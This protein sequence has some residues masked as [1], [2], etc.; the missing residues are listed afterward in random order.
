LKEVL[1]TALELNEFFSAY[2]WREIA[3]ACKRL[4][5]SSEPAQREYGLDLLASFTELP[6]ELEQDLIQLLINTSRDSEA[7]LSKK[8]RQSL[9]RF[10]ASEKLSDLSRQLLRDYGDDQP[11]LNES[12]N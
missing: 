5:Q 10:G 9:D 12:K 4:L 3:H 2:E 8:A 11:H 6:G 7:N 1:D